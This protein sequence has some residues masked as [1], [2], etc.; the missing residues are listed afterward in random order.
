MSI[1]SEKKKEIFEFF[2]SSLSRSVDDTELLRF[3]KELVGLFGKVI[4]GYKL[5]PRSNPAFSK[6]GDQFKAKLD[7]IFMMLPTISL[8][9]SPKGFMVGK[10]VL[11]T[12]EK[13]K[14]IVFFLYNDGLR[15]IFFQKGTTREEVT[16]LFNILAQCTLFANEDYD[17]ATL[18]WDHNF[19]NIGYITEDELIKENVV[20]Y[21]DN[22]FSPFLVEE[23]AYGEGINSIG[24]GGDDGEGDEGNSPEE[25]AKG[26]GFEQVDF[27][28]YATLIFKESDNIDLNEIKERLDKRIENHSVGK[29]EMFKFDEALKKNSDGFVVNRFLRELSSRLLLSQGSPEGLELLETAASLWEKLLLFGSV[30]GAILFIKTLKMIADKLENDQPDYSRKIR[31]GFS[32]L[33]DTSFLD[34]VFSTIEDLPDEEMVAVGEL[35]Q[36][37]PPSKIGYLVAKINDLESASARIAVIDSFSKYIVI[38]DELL[39]LTKHEDWKVV[40]NVFVLMKDKKDA[41]IVPAIRSTLSHPQKQARI[42]ALALLMEF[43][44]E[45]AMPALEKAVFS[46]EREIRAIAVRKVLE[47]KEPRVKAIVNRALQI[48]NLK[49]LDKDEADEYLKLLIDMRREDMYDLISNLLFSDDMEMKNKAVTAI[50][51]APT[52]TPFAKFISRA[53]DISIVSKMKNDDLKNFCR[54]Y[55]PETYKELFPALEPLFFVSG[56]LFNK[57]VKTLKETIFRSLVIYIDDPAVVSFFKKGISNGNKETVLLIDKIAA[58]YL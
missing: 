30:N 45:E 17:L 24:D 41:R 50:L 34:D 32:S 42:E 55:K 43:S 23:L 51:E 19:S 3:A 47:L 40:R 37:V 2:N 29:M 54:L 20:S 1:A 14:E 58:K 16:E 7:D 5:Y 35:F 48:S 11:D 12:N 52:L 27:E 46:S 33:E 56:G 6:F 15:E 31:E 28:K 49:K 44:I 36:M 57:T 22:A 21:E 39:E 9:I 8:K 53:S 18:L 4:R 26:A 13:D 25:S 38:T 10:S